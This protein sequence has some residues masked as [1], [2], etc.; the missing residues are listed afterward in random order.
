MRQ[1]ALREGRSGSAERGRHLWGI[2]EAPVVRHGPFSGL[3]YPAYDAFGSLLCP[4][5]IGSYEKEL[6][7]VIGP[8]FAETYTDIIDIGCAEGYYA[9]GLAKVFPDAQVWAFDPEPKA[10]ESC[11]EMAD[12]NGVAGRVHI[13]A[14][15][16]P[17]T[18]MQF[19]NKRCLV[20]CDCEGYELSLFNG[21][22]IA[23]LKNS[24]L[25]IET[26]DLNGTEI[27]G[28]L[29][30]RFSTTHMVEVISSIDDVTKARTYR[31][32]ET[33]A[34]SFRDRLEMFAEGRRSQ[35]EWLVCRP[36]T[37]RT[38]TE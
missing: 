11:R 19:A 2:L 15:C 23:A 20:V 31:Y 28:P 7:P 5:L 3:R 24:D 8:L 35:M 34:L 1:V 36:K 10:M 32:P 12:L 33:D 18:L 30:A 13:G 38:P 6:Q 26:H 17:E 4:K 21:E 14:Y 9:V 27:A 37:S 22:N 16:Q 25:I 29:A